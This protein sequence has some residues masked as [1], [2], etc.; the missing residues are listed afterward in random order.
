MTYLAL[1]A[2]T[3]LS[4]GL[5]ATAKT[6]RLKKDQQWESMAASPDQRYAQAVARL[7]RLV[8]SGDAEA[9]EE[10]LTQLKEQFPERVGP[11]LDAFVEGELLYW[12]DKYAKALVKYEKFLKDYPGSEFADLVL[13]RE[14]V[15]G[16]A[17]LDGRKKTVLGFIRMSGHA[18]GVEIMERISDRA[19]LDEP[20][21]VGLRA[22]ISVAEH[23]ERR[24]KYLEAYLKWS[25]IASYWDSGPVGR[26]AILRM[27]ED[28]RLAY[29]QER[30]GRRHLYDSSKL[31]TA[32]TY[33]EKLQLRFPADAEQH[34]ASGK[35]KLV[36]EKMAHKE[37]MIGQYYQRTGKRQAA[38]LYFD[39]VMQNWPGTEAAELAKQ[40]IE[41]NMDEA[42]GGAK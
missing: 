18:E 35:I 4:C 21:S 22:A 7:R 40:A 41:R 39:M 38:N 9:A 33:Y 12:T 16:Q 20:N 42:V 11:D 17:Y 19:G 2:S 24:E 13:E 23:Y 6:W 15:I 3:I 30:E 1:L 29:D 27:A 36:D 26:R 34:D 25:E 37:L 32:K 10:A 31:T 8:Q 5:T 14:W 28:N